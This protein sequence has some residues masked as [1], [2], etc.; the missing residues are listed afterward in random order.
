MTTHATYQYEQVCLR[1]ALR[2][3][4]RAARTPGVPDATPGQRAE[5]AADA[6]GHLQAVTR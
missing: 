3:L 4:R 6:L 1:R 2:A 5:A